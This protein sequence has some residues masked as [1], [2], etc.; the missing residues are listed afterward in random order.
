[1]K[2]WEINIQMTNAARTEC[3][4]AVTRF[5]KWGSQVSLVDCF[6]QKL[7]TCYVPLKGRTQKNTSL[8]LWDFGAENG[9][10]VGFI[11]DSILN[12]I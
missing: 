7:D 2:G 8:E 5:G 1:M 4:K 6:Y 11:Y 12:L 9:V 3:H 10:H